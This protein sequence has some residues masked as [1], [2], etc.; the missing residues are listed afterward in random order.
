M[1]VYSAGGPVFGGYRY[2][3]EDAF[4]HLQDYDTCPDCDGEGAIEVSSPQTDDPYYCR[5][6]RCPTCEGCGWV[7]HDGTKG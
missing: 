2:P 5:T 3:Q 6:E 4:D 1:K 7:N